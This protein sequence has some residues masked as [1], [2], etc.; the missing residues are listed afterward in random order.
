MGEGTAGGALGGDSVRFPNLL[1]PLGIESPKTGVD[2]PMIWP[3]PQHIRYVSREPELL[4]VARPNLVEDM[5]FADAQR[6][7]HPEMVLSRVV[8]DSVDRPPSPEL[9]SSSAPASARITTGSSR[10]SSSSSSSVE[11]A[12]SGSDRGGRSDAK[13]D[14]KS[15]A[16][17]GGSSAGSAGSAG[18]GTVPPSAPP[19]SARSGATPSMT[20]P[21]STLHPFYTLPDD[22]KDSTLVFESRFEGGNLRRAIQVRR[23]AREQI[24]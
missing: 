4:Y 14:A 12:C 17:A 21:S 8:Y 24:R 16:N 1:L 19:G 5:V 6:L 2:I 10:R 3:P 9:A 15:D 13:S 20:P 23:E 11:E 22:A 7:A 18:P